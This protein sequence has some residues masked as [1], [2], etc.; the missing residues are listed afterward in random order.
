MLEKK[1][2]K[3]I[4]SI[5]LAAFLL[6]TSLSCD[7]RTPVSSPP[8]QLSYELQLFCNDA[9]CSNVTAYAANNALGEIEITAQLS[10]DNDEDG[11]MDG[12][13]EGQN[14][15]FSWIKDDGTPADGY[16]QISE[17]YLPS[18]GDATNIGLTNVNGVVKGVWQ[19]E[20]DLGNFEVKAIY[21]DQYDVSVEETVSITLVSPESLINSVVGY[22]SAT[23]NTLEVPDNNIYTTNINARVLNEQG[24]N[25]PNI[26]V[27]FTKVSGSGSLS[28]DTA[29]TGSDGVASVEYQ[30]APGTSDDIVS[31]SVTVD[32]PEDCGTDCTD[33][34][35]LTITSE[36]FPQEYY[37]RAFNLES[38][39]FQDN[40]SDGVKDLLLLDSAPDSTYTII[41]EVTTQ[42]SANIGVPNVP[43]YYRNLSDDSGDSYGTIVTSMPAYT[44]DGA[45]EPSLLGVA[46]AELV[47]NRTD[48]PLGYGRIQIEASIHDP[49]DFNDI[50][51]ID[52]NGTQ[53][54]GT[55]SV[56]VLTEQY[57]I[58]EAIDD[59]LISTNQTESFENNNSIT[60]ETVITARTIDSFGGLVT[61]PVAIN[62]DFVGVSTPCE[63]IT[64]KISL[65]IGFTLVQY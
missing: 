6:L 21:T 60:Y 50:L 53:A 17:G 47:I 40:N 58:I 22:T 54:L 27:N 41:F 4:L 45:L 5:M 1:Y 13:H 26:D 9:E 55:V 37:V 33:T 35:Q 46:Q 32:G 48:I 38:N 49:D 65:K 56:D 24:V 2:L 39:L 3:P 62:Y 34:F 7:E 28:S 8:P 61:D 64:P 42:D 12:G 44:N 11:V 20:S 57:A 59:L 51:V 63:V 10:I 36:I 31:F 15:V 30:T 43:V 29:K 14:I 25:L 18:S 52:E 16:F 19:D 23:N